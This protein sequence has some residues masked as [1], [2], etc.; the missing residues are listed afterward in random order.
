MKTMIEV[1]IPEG[2]TVSEA[3]D[4]WIDIGKNQTKGKK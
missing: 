3:I 1:D 2:R 4:V